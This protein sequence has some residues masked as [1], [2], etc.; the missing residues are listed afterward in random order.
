M[1]HMIL[2]RA[3]DNFLTSSHTFEIHTTV[4][5]SM[6]RLSSSSFLRLLYD[7][8]NVL[9][10]YSKTE[11]KQDIPMW[12]FMGGFLLLCRQVCLLHIN[13]SHVPKLQKIL[14]S[15]SPLVNGCWCRSLEMTVEII[16]ED[17]CV[18]CRLGCLEWVLALYSCESS[19]IHLCV[20]HSHVTMFCMYMHDSVCV[21]VRG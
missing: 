3:T 5:V 14:W 7:L 9:M 17:Q 15:V 4:L 8:I 19:F 6:G 13:N 12:M 16:K 10:S 21:C 20:L 2:S 11:H 1:T 18:D